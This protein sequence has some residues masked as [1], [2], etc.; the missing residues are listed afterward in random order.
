MHLALGLLNGGFKLRCEFQVILN[1]VVQPL[2][3]F[4]QF[5]LLEIRKFGFGLSDL[6]Q[7]VKILRA[8]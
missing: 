3:D 2:A 6:T 5:R 4:S 1:H 8:T 7:A